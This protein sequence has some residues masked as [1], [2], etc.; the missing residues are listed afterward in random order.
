[1]PWMRPS[2]PSATCSTSGGPG[3]EV[4]TTST[5]P[6]TARG[7]SFQTAP[8]ARCGSAAARRTSCTA[9]AWPAA[10]RLDAMLAPMIPSPMKPT[11]MARFLPAGILAQPSDRLLDYPATVCLTTRRPF[12]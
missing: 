10:W 5:A 2:G 8:A 4:K 7:L 3:S 6:A 9:S 1:M 11:F 12:A